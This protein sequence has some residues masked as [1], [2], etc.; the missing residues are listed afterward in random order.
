ML[1]ASQAQLGPRLAYPIIVLRLIGKM[2]GFAIARFQGLGEVDGGFLVRGDAKVPL[3]RGGAAPRHRQPGV[4]DDHLRNFAVAVAHQSG[5]GLAKGAKCCNPAATVKLQN[6]RAARR[7]CDRCRLRAGLQLGNR[8]AAIG[9]KDGWFLRIRRRRYP[10]VE[11]HVVAGGCHRGRKRK[12][13]AR[14]PVR[15]GIGDSDQQ[16]QNNDGAQGKRVARRQARCRRADRHG[17]QLFGQP[18]AVGGPQLC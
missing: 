3:Q 12:A 9:Q 15:P 5:S 7:H 16:R 8:L 4:G 1:F 11:P 13:Q 17:A 2:Q 14:A 10:G 6:Q 18:L